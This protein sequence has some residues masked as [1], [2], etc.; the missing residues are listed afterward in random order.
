MPCRLRSRRRHRD[1]PSPGPTNIPSA[2]R[3]SFSAN[4]A[5]RPTEPARSTPSVL[6]AAL[7][8]SNRYD[9]SGKNDENARIEITNTITTCADV[10][11]A[12][13]DQHTGHACGKPS[14]FAVHVCCERI[15]DQMEPLV[16]PGS[17]PYLLPTPT[18]L[19][20]LTPIPRQT[21]CGTSP[22]TYTSP[23]QSP[24]PP[25]TSPSPPPAPL[26]LRPLRLRSGDN[27]GSGAARLL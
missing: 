2:K 6:Q 12:E 7:G 21:A 9:E 4:R 18:V 15:V 5:K 16:A 27:A 23:S 8:P 19:L 3:H 25:P 13:T 11:I 26:W 17:R 1:A 20:H 22:H 14:R 10:A 24:P